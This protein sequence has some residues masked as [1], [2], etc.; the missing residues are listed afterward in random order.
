MRSR[1]TMTAESKEHDSGSDKELNL[2]NDPNC[3]KKGK[4]C[5]LEM[6]NGFLQDE[7]QRS[8]LF[9]MVRLSEN[10]MNT[11]R[12]NAYRLRRSILDAD[13]K[14]LQ[15]HL[16]PP[17][18]QVPG[19]QS[20]MTQKEVAGTLVKTLHKGSS[21]GGQLSVSVNLM[22]IGEPTSAEALMMLQHLPTPPNYS[23]KGKVE[24]SV[25]TSIHSNKNMV[26]LHQ[27]ATPRLAQMDDSSFPMSTVSPLFRNGMSPA[28]ARFRNRPGFKQ[29]E[30]GV[31]T[32]QESQQ[33]KRSLKRSAMSPIASRLMQMKDD[34]K[35]GAITQEQKISMKKDLIH[36]NLSVRTGNNGQQVGKTKLS[37][38]FRGMVKGSGSP[39]PKRIRR[40]DLSKDPA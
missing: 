19:K 2:L 13:L 17:S 15:Q 39:L 35:N 37:D 3:W 31:T 12:T 40:P 33:K 34:V 30:L 20:S 4:N 9:S 7:M 5:A 18:P 6:T 29:D 28:A 11:S 1:Q 23:I 36:E 22:S 8:R 24:T 32:T 26:S 38:N 14:M 27:G 25:D 10:E 21:P 16:P